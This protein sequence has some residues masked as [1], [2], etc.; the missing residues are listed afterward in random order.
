MLLMWKKSSL[1]K[2]V[3]G[4]LYSGVMRLVTVPP[5]KYFLLSEK[6]EAFVLNSER[7]ILLGWFRQ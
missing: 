5:N 3:M 7:E 1:V 2:E 4:C 6:W